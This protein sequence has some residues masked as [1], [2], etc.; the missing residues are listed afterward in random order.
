MSARL[1]IP[2]RRFCI[3]AIPEQMHGV[4]AF[5]RP[6]TGDFIYV[7][8]AKNL[9]IR[10]RLK[11]HWHRSHSKELNLWLNAFPGQIEICYLPVERDK[12]D[13]VEDILIKKWNPK[14]NKNQKRR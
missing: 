6:R 13:R 1:K 9:T 11:S 4:Y 10:K 12:I 8:K 14:T 7:G 2:L 5:W 3:E